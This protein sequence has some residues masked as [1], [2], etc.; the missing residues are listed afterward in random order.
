LERKRVLFYLVVLSWFALVAPVLSFIFYLI[1][2][3]LEISANIALLLA[4]Y[5]IMA[6]TMLVLVFVLTRPPKYLA[7][8]LSLQRKSRGN[9][10]VVAVICLIV[11]VLYFVGGIF[12]YAK[13]LP[14]I[15]L[16]E[17]VDRDRYMLLQWFA[18][19]VVFVAVVGYLL[20]EGFDVR[21]SQIIKI[22]SG[23]VEQKES[24]QHTS[25]S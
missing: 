5:V 22:G 3:E 9:K 10:I 7:R 11:L 20:S 16:M 12:L 24:D 23:R 18:W 17:I 8:Y 4:K 2:T 14:S 15:D 1:W 21:L 19:D 13:I 25:P 6:A